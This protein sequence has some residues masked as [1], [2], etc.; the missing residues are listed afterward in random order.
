M[1][2][3]LFKGTFAGR[4][5]QGHLAR[6]REILCL[7]EQDAGCERDVAERRLALRRRRPSGRVEGGRPAGNVVGDR[8]GS[9]RLGNAVSRLRQKPQLVQASFA[10]AGLKIDTT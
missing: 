1:L 3:I 4:D 2:V 9:Q 5:Q 10:Q 8:K 7:V 6:E